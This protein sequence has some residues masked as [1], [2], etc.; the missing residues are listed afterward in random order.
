MNYGQ[1]KAA[2]KGY[3]HR[4]DIDSMFPTFLLL[5]EQRI[6]NGE[7]NTPAL[8]ISPMLKTATL[9]TGV[10]PTDFLEAKRVTVS[11]DER[12][13][14]EYRPLS[15]LQV[16]SRAYSWRGNEIVLC[17]HEEFPVDLLY[18]AKVTTLA[19]DADTNWLLT[20]AP[21]VYLTSML[22]EAARW[23]MNADL[24]MREAANYASAIGVLMSSDSAAQHSG[25]M[26]RP[27]VRGV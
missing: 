17:P 7:Q 3:L 9:V 23:S 6:H 22:V 24:G 13:T 10:R 1:L 26:L 8:R 25:S 15:D 2:V 21:N 16:S 11:G 18:Y 19:D 14:L 12:K 5:T 20:A 4:N 27:K